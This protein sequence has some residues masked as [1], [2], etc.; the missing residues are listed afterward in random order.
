MP[1]EVE[2]A[3]LMLD[4]DTLHLRSPAGHYLALPRHRIAPDL[5][6]ELEQALHAPPVPPADE[7]TA[8]RRAVSLN[9]RI[10]DSDA[11]Q[12]PTVLEILGIVNPAPR[13]ESE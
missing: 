9:V 10:D 7:A 8:F 12:A 5:L 13:G 6:C 4:V 1:R 3:V 11:R 2:L